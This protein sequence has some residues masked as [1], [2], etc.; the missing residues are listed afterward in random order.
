MSYASRLITI[1]EQDI[2]FLEKKCDD[3]KEE[4]ARLKAENKDYKK[5]WQVVGRQIKDLVSVIKQRENIGEADGEEE[6][7][8]EEEEE[9]EEGQN[10]EEGENQDEGE[11]ERQCSAVKS[12]R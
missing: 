12:R 11:E 3:I 9:E 6:I 7:E 1:L 10:Q 8:E 2:S 5:K 4:N